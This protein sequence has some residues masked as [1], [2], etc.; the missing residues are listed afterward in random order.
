MIA[1]PSL[2][3]A[4]GGHGAAVVGHE[5]IEKM[6]RWPVIEMASRPSTLGRALASVIG[7]GSNALRRRAERSDADHPGAP[8]EPNLRKA[9]ATAED[10]C[11]AGCGSRFTSCSSEPRTVTDDA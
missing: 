10:P 11:V 7:L 4:A 2:V 1:A 3:P 5:L 8:T 9:C 6:S